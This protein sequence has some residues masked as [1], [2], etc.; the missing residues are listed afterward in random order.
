MSNI[1]IFCSACSKDLSNQVF[2]AKLGTAGA[3]VSLAVRPASVS[4]DS[5]FTLSTSSKQAWPTPGSTA[6]RA[7]GFKS[8]SEASPKGPFLRAGSQARMP[9]GHM[10]AGRVFAPATWDLQLSARP[11]RAAILIDRT[12][13][14]VH[15]VAVPRVPL[16]RHRD[17]GPRVVVLRLHIYP[18]LNIS[19]LYIII[20]VCFICMCIVYLPPERAA[21]LQKKAKPRCATRCRSAAAR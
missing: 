10:H 8:L 19:L 9:L 13:G 21:F 11:P 17:R 16:T 12:Q 4:R 18:Y 2:G 6:R 15:A 14:G 20:C 1:C 3:R 5:R 7:P